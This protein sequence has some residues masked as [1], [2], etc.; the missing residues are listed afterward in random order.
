M[1]E[2][3]FHLGKGRTRV[4]IPE[5]NL[6]GVHS[7]PRLE[8]GQAPE[9]V[10]RRSVSDPIGAEPITSS[11]DEG[12]NV[13]IILDDITRQT[14]THLILPQLASE[15][16]S[17]GVRDED[18]EVLFALGTHR[19]MTRAEMETKA[20][21]DMLG[22]FEAVN[23]Y[24]KDES[25]LDDLGTTGSGIPI[26]VNRMISEADW[27]IGVGNIVPHRVAGY[28]GG[29]KI[30]Q[31]GL[32]GARTTGLTHMLSGRFEGED[33]LGVAENPVRREIE[34]IAD[35]A[36]L[37]M[38]V[39]TVLDGEANLLSAFSG[40][41][42]EAHR[43]GVEACDDIYTVPIGQK[44]DI[45]V[46]DSHPADLDMW[47]AV[48][49]LE[50]AELA[51]RPGGT[52]VLLTPCWEGVSSEHPEL[53]EHGYLYPDDAISMM[54]SGELKDLVSTAAMVH[55][56]KILEKMR[57]IVY[58]LGIKRRD[59]ETLGFEYASSAQEAVDEALKGSGPSA[60]VLAFKGAAEIVPRISGRES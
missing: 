17:A 4:E 51:A 10:L 60:E 47:Q 20:G 13:L 21:A 36:G 53:E 14:P 6:L 59:V 5:R 19:Y 33:V 16:R 58:A 25:M 50:A 32:G 49:A 26:T 12:D 42:V 9:E 18:V 34:E 15:L 35:R 1:T 56:G 23:H 37:D 22:R 29:G 8:T 41:T 54:E 48:K 45:V 28:T 30:V 57:V 3:F 55:V 46:V 7:P 2:I 52:I 38:I 31:P 24:W 39:N 11:V 40:D 44:A 43:A 27:S